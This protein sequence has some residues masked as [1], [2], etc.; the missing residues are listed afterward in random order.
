MGGAAKLLAAMLSARDP[1]NFTYDEAVTVLRTL[2]FEPA[3]TKPKGSHRLWRLEVPADNGVRTVHV[4][5][6]Q[7]GHGTLKPIYVKKMLEVL[8]QNH[9]ISKQ[10]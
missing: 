9:L 7:A 10:A 2:G 1:R 8:L 4:G 5:L 6:V 3:R